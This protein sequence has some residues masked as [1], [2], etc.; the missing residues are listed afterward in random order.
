MK[1]PRK[2]EVVLEK[3]KAVFGLEISGKSY[4]SAGIETTEK[5][6]AGT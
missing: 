1:T 4:L 2:E 3:T 5:T 6:F